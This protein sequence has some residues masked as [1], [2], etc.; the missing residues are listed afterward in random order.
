MGELG[1]LRTLSRAVP[2]SPSFDLLSTL[3]NM[4]LVSKRNV[5]SARHGP[6]SRA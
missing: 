2:P 5:E 6:L 4:V 3:S 1:D